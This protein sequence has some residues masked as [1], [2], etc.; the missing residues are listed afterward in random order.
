MLHS[1]PLVERLPPDAPLYG[2][3][4]ESDTTIDGLDPACSAVVAVAIVGEGVE[5][6]IRGPEPELLTELDDVIARLPIGVLV[7]WNGARFDL[8]FLA[9]RAAVSAIPLGLELWTDPWGQP[10]GQPL[11]GHSDVRYRAQWHGHAHLDGYRLY[12][13]DA[14]RGLGLSCALKNLA[15][16]VGLQP[17]QVDRTRIHE[18]TDDELCAYVASDAYLA[19]ELVARRG[20]VALASADLR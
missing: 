7:T 9:D 12:R 3:D 6:V 16:L 19:R 11:P 17:V 5:V 13:S 1:F 15:R 2:L 20:R 10:E 18:L 8:P 14:G 4:I